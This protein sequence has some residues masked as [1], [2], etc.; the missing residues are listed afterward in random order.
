MTI[1]SPEIQTAAENTTYT[2]L[3]WIFAA[4]TGPATL[5]AEP[6]ADDPINSKSERM[7]IACTSSFDE[8]SDQW[9]TDHVLR[10]VG[11]G[12]S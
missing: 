8:I 1:R 4:R 3:G 2:D 9:G 5:L 6:R 7:T 10:G 11:A 12:V